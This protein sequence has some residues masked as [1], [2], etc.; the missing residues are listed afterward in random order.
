MSEYFVMEC[1]AGPGEPEP[2]IGQWPD[3]AGVD[4]WWTGAPLA[5]S[6]G[7]EIRCTLHPS[8]AEGVLPMFNDEILLMTRPLVSCLFDAGVDNLQCFPAVIVNPTDGTADTGY[9]AVNVLGIVRAADLAASRL[10]PSSS[11]SLIGVDFESLVIDP[12]A[13]RD[14]NL[15][16]L[17]ECVTAIVTHERVRRVIAEHPEFAKV[18][19]VAPTEWI[20]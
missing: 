2:M 19:F 18:R 15:F 5:I 6:P 16:R 12:K 13:A 8:Y 11:G 7:T 1:N 9:W 17:A 10:A 20:G 4:S 14:L 3:I